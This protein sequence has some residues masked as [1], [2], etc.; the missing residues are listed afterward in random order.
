MKG[1]QS[2]MYR[3]LDCRDCHVDL[4]HL[5]RDVFVDHGLEQKGLG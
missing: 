2:M 4:V 3:H 5:C 1:L